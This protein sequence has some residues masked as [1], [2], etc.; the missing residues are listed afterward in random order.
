MWLWCNLISTHTRT[1][2]YTHT[3][4]DWVLKGEVGVMTTQLLEYVARFDGGGD[5]GFGWRSYK[6]I[7]TF[8]VLSL[9]LKKRR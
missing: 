6:E 4:T 8:S 2:A 9:Q 1:H 7:H 5:V 3:H